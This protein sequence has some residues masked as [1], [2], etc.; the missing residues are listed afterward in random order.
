MENETTEY[1]PTQEMKDR[2]IK[3]VRPC[4]EH[5]A[6]SDIDRDVMVWLDNLPVREDQ[7][8]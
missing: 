3:L 6:A 7:E 8:L 1:L 5:Y 2:L 4:A